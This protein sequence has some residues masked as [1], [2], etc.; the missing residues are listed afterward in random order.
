MVQAVAGSFSTRVNF[1]STRDMIENMEAHSLQKR[2]NDLLR[3]AFEGGPDRLDFDSVEDALLCALEVHTFLQE[4]V[5]YITS[6]STS[7]EV[8]F[9]RK[10]AEGAMFQIEGAL[11]TNK[12]S[13]TDELNTTVKRGVRMAK[14]V[15]DQLD[16]G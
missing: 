3:R 16:T 6:V 9:L 13:L 1:G 14:F 7:P 2:S 11:I 5:L 12:A 8:V 4:L 10:A 15:S